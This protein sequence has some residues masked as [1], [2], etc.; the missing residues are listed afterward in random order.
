[1]SEGTGPNAWGMTLESA[2]ELAE[3]LRADGWEVVTVRAA[4]VGP[5]A[6][7]DG[8]TDRFGY[9][10]VA[11]GDVAESFA[12]VVEE[13]E[14]DSFVVRS[15]TV[16]NDRFMITQVSDTDR[17][18]AVL[19]VG[20]VPVSEVTQLA[21][22]ASEAGEMYSHVQLLDGMHLGSFH[23]DDPEPFFPEGAR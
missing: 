15:R 9:V 2:T 13:G 8:E 17:E 18:V 5:E 1:M 21:R 19:L 10:Y 12:A 20:A 6:P 4:H 14:F 16:G 7:A 11:P 23:H 22:A 3:E